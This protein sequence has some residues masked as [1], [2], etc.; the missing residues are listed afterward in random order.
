MYRKKGMFPSTAVG[1][2]DEDYAFV[3][4]DVDFEKSILEGLITITG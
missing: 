1:L 3:S 4:I 2:D